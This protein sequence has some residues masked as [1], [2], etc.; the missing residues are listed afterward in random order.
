M[1]ESPLIN[2]VWPNMKMLINNE[3]TVSNLV[4]TVKKQ[5][6]QSLHNILPDYIVDNINIILTH[7]N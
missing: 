3:N 7:V 1:D 4:T 2:K 5:D 6:L